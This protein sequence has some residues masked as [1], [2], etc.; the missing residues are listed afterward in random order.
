MFHEICSTYKDRPAESEAQHD[1]DL[2]CNLSLPGVLQENA[3]NGATQNV[4]LDHQKQRGRDSEGY[5]CV[6]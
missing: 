1:E 5:A 6:E 3:G 2:D 4:K